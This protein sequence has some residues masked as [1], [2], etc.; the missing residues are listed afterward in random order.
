MVQPPG[1]VHRAVM[2]VVGCGP[3]GELLEVLFAKE[4]RPSVPAADNDL[5]VFVRHMVGQHLGTHGGGDAGGGQI[6][7]QAHGNA[8]Q[9]APV[10]SERYLS[11]R[12]LRL[13]HGPFVK[14]G[15]ERVQRGL[16]TVRLGQGGFGQLHGGNFFVLNHGR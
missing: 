4:D 9:R 7:L 6:V 14:D 16:Q 5:G 13:G 8:V 11:L 15:D 3:G 1:V 2:G 12:L 10:V